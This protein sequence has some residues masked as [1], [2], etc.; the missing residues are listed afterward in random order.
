MAPSALDLLK[1][2]VVTITDALSVAATRGTFQ[3]LTG[4]SRHVP[5]KR[6]A[7]WSAYH[8]MARSDSGHLG[9]SES[10]HGSGWGDAS[11]RRPSHTWLDRNSAYLI[12]STADPIL[13][14][15][16]TQFNLE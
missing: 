5:I 14:S 15:S 11:L 1:V 9:G 10:C 8:A 6:V 4:K 16:Q 7:L 12:A 2:V 13:P 3:P